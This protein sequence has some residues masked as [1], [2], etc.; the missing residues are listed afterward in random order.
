M[1]AEYI[2]LSSALR[3]VI[4]LMTLLG[5][6]KTIFKLYLP[7]PKVICKV[8]EDNMICI[9]MAKNQ[10][11]SPRTKHISLKYHQFR[12]HIERVLVDIVHVRTRN[13]IAD[14]LTKP[15]EEDAF[16]YLRKLLCGW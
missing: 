2:A 4:T 14:I 12:I 6:L 1:E 13:Q 16:K 3:E 7:T 15:L 8:Y 11:F 10:K 5:E 9:A